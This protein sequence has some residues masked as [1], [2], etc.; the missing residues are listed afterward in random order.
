MVPADGTIAAHSH[1]PVNSAH[2]FRRQLSLMYTNRL[3]AARE[4]SQAAATGL[5][6]RK[7]YG[8]GRS[9]RLARLE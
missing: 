5:L 3:I 2:P 4:K 8:C 6:N 7:C 1:E 9:A